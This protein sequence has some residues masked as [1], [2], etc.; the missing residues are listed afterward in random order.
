MKNSVFDLTPKWIKG[1]A[2]WSGDSNGINMSVKGN[3]TTAG[4][5]T[6]QNIPHSIDTD[7]IV[8]QVLHLPVDPFA[9]KP[10]SPGG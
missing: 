7:L 8:A 1:P 5:Q 3:L 9:S 2:G 6:T 10:L 4:T